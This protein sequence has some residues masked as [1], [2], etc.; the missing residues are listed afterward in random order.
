MKNMTKKNE[1][2][3]QK[4]Y[5]TRTQ[6]GLRKKPSQPTVKKM[7]PWKARDEERCEKSNQT[8]TTLTQIGKMT[9]DMGLTDYSRL[10]ATLHCQVGLSGNSNPL[11]N[12]IVT[13]A[14]TQY[15][16]SKGIKKFGQ[17]GIDAV[18]VELRQLHERMVMDPKDATKMTTEEKRIL[19]ST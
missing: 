15:H 19:C 1:A 9:T 13:T 8:A 11:R 12:D 4:K 7:M 16:V 6:T 2:S 14:L 10:Y 17:E 18:L 3:Q 5:G